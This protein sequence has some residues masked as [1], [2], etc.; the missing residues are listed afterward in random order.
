M[1]YTLKLMR[2]RPG[3]WGY[4]LVNDV[5]GSFSES[6]GF[7]TRGSILRMLAFRRY[8]PKDFIAIEDY[9][10]TGTNWR[11]VKRV[12]ARKDGERCT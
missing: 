7:R 12:E 3:D 1:T 5:G 2:S 4:D 11:L 9:H 8:D 6:G 10:W